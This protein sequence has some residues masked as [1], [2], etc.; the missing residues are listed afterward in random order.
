MKGFLAELELGD[1][2][3]VADF[4]ARQELVRADPGARVKAGSAF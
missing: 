4:G 2:P 3:A 1:G